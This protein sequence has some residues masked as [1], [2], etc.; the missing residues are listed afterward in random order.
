MECHSLA[1][2]ETPLI[3]KGRAARHAAHS[4]RYAYA[5]LHRSCTRSSCLD[6]LIRAVPGRR[7]RYM[8]YFQ[9]RLIPELQFAAYDW[10]FLEF[11][12]RGSLLGAKSPGAAVRPLHSAHKTVGLASH[13]CT[14][15][16][17][18]GCWLCPTVRRLA[19]P[20][21]ASAARSVHVDDALWAP[22]IVHF[23]MQSICAD[24]FTDECVERYK[25]AFARPG[26]M[27]AALNYYRASHAG[28]FGFAQQRDRGCA[29][30]HL[31]CAHM[32]LS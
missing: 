29:Q 12:Y 32:A 18:A 13:D 30:G 3:D 11:F 5:T 17:A 21:C 9:S 25:Q 16:V 14:M 8:W 2:C 15:R 19:A 4:G 1:R 28:A 22:L 6:I 10:A 24:A 23:L 7:S 27:T 31:R 20:P 26:S